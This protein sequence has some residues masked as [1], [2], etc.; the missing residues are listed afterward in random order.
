[1]YINLCCRV[2]VALKTCMYVMYVHYVYI[3]YNVCGHICMSCM[4]YVSCV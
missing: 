2:V 3:L 4:L 1:M